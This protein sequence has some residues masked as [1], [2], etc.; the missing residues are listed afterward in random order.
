MKYKEN[1]TELDAVTF[2][3]FANKVW[4]GSYDIKKIETA[5]SKTINITAYDGET[6]VG[7]LRV[8]SDEYFF[9]TITELLVL[10]K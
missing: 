10:P 5:L 8:L 3:V 1:D 7:S 6:L 9:G 4:E 2:A